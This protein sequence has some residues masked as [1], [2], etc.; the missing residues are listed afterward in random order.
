M[1]AISGNWLCTCGGQQLKIDSH[2]ETAASAWAHTDVLHHRSISSTTRLWKGYVLLAWLEIPFTIL[3][4]VLMPQGIIMLLLFMSPQWGNLI[5]VFFFFGNETC[6]QLLCWQADTH[7]TLLHDH[8][9]HP[10]FAKHQN[11]LGSFLK[12][13]YKYNEYWLILAYFCNLSLS[14]S[15]GYCCSL[16]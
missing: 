12:V 4:T 7:S 8:C 11:A 13:I 16:W 1:P 9:T 3:T 15:L 10:T 5:D 14:D 6:C 2:P